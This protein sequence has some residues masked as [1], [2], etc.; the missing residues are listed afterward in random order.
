MSEISMNSLANKLQDLELC[1]KSQHR[2]EVVYGRALRKAILYMDLFM[3]L[4]VLKSLG[5]LHLKEARQRHDS[6]EFDKAAAMYS[7]A[8]LRCTDSDMRE[9]LKHR[10]SYMEKL[11]RQLMQGYTP[12]YHWLFPDYWGTAHSNRLCVAKTCLKLDRG[13][14]KLW[15][16]VEEAYTETMVTAMG[17]GDVFLEVEVLKSLGDFYLSG[18]GKK[19]SGL[20]RFSKAAAMYGKALVRCEDP[21]TRQA[22]HHRVLYLVKTWGEV[23]RRQSSLSSPNKSKQ[24]G[25]T[26]PKTH[27]FGNINRPDVSRGHHPHPD[28]HID[29]ESSYQDE[30]QEGCRALE[31]GD[32]DMAEQ[33]FAAALKCVHF[34][35][36]KPDQHSKEAEPLYKLGDVYLKKGIQSKDG[37]DF[38]KAAALC[39][40]ALVRSRR[41]DINE[42]IQEISK[43]FVKHVLNIKQTV[44]IGDTEKHK[45]MLRETRLLLV[46][47]R[48]R[49]PLGAN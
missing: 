18:N 41:E 40:A 23:M 24:R 43:S 14:G 49:H 11:C 4:E 33:H 46:R 5:D 13:V 34:K 42:V 32:L 1:L 10:I 44:V 7:T 39:N 28:I 37:E 26:S 6:A 30:M 25:G 3:E 17:K 35:D 12:Q 16:S 45:L 29:F 15:Q 9:T 36:S 8:L 48:F 20:S 21:E 47:V 38:T 19:T 2:Q 22:L 31:T 27:Q